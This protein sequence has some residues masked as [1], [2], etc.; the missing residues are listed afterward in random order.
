MNILY[1]QEPDK[2]SKGQPQIPKRFENPNQ[3]KTVKNGPLEKD[4]RT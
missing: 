2:T 1:P 4:F 3:G